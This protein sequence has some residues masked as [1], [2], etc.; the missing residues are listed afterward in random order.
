MKGTRLDSSGSVPSLSA[1]ASAGGANGPWQVLLGRH[2]SGTPAVNPLCKEPASAVPAPTALTVALRVGGPD[3][4]VVMAVQ[5]IP[6]TTGSVG[7]PPATSSQQIVVRG[8]V[9]RFVIPA[10]ADGEAYVLRLG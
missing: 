7:D 6:D 3:R 9:A 5:R 2:Q 1:F 4:A 8:G 10:F